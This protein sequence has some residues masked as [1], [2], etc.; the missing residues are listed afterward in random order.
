MATVT[1]SRNRKK[2]IESLFAK[3]TACTVYTLDAGFLGA[4]VPVEVLRR[5]LFNVNCPGKLTQTGDK[6]TIHVHSNCW[7]EFRVTETHP[8]CCGCADCEA[9]YAA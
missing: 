4:T 7:Y 2:Y 5:A 9:R 1:I 3:A 8:A 6:C